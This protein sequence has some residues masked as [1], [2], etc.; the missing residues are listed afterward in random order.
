MC[1]STAG[2]SSA[3]LFTQWELPKQRDAFT[4]G[5]LNSQRLQRAEQSRGPG[6]CQV[7]TSLLQDRPPQIPYS[8]FGHPGLPPGGGP[9]HMDGGNEND[10]GSNTDEDEL[11]E[12]FKHL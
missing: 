3:S 1:F 6:F 9:K 2:T 4:Q 8:K 10:A 5:I 11:M 12:K 7:D